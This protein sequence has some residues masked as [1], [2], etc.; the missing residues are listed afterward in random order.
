MAY[1]QAQIPVTKAAEFE[2]LKSA[3]ERVLESAASL[4]RLFRK[5]ESKG[6]RVREVEKIIQAGLL[7]QSDPQLARSGKSG[8]QMYE[9]LALSDQALLREFYLERVEQV[10][11]AVREKFGKI[12]R[13]Y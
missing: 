13:Y 2:Q 5:I 4:D 11:P 12:Y 6:L 10:D 8:R 7:E 1:Q 9:S 3:L